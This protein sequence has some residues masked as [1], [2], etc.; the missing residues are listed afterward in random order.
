MYIHNVK[1]KK[2]ITFTNVFVRNFVTIN[3]SKV[4]VVMFLTQLYK[5]TIILFCGNNAT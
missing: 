1:N 5:L 3:L 2:I 4:Y